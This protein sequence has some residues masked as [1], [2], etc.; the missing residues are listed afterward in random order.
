MADSQ[1]FVFVLWCH[2]ANNSNFL[3]LCELAY[4]KP[5]PL[6]Q[7]YNAISRNNRKSL[8]TI[9]TIVKY[10]PGASRFIVMAVPQMVCPHLVCT[11]WRLADQDFFYMASNFIHENYERNDP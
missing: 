5:R 4:T 6:W 1:K 11:W 10:E 9:V 2:H 8:S 7:L 3:W